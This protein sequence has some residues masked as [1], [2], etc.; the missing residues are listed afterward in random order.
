MKGHFTRELQVIERAV[1]DQIFLVNP[2]NE[3][4]YHLNVTGTALWRLLAEPIS[5][6]DAIAV[7]Q[8][9][10]PDED[11][12]D[13]ETDVAALFTEFAGHGLIVEVD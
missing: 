12:T 6:E 13:I 2:E 10:F 11:R 9:A 8:D 3:E 7:L 4:I 1:G 5:L